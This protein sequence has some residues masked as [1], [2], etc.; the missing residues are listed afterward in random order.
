MNK[1][2]A[3]NWGLNSQD[4]A[5]VAT[6]VQPGEEVV[7]VVKPCITQS[8]PERWLYVGMGLILLVWLLVDWDEIELNWLL[9]LIG[10]LLVLVPRFHR[11]RMERTLYLMTN[12]RVVILEPGL[13]FGT[14]TTAYPL[15][16]GL[17]KSVVPGSGD[18]GD[19]VFAYEPRWKIVE[20][21]LRREISPVGFMAVPQVGR[22]AR[23]IAEQVVAFSSTEAQLPPIPGQVSAPVPQPTIPEPLPMPTDSWGNPRPQEPSRGALIGFGAV[24]ALFSLVFAI[25]GGYR[26][27]ADAR[28]DAEGVRAVATVVKVNAKRTTSKRPAS[29]HGSGISIRIGDSRKD[30]SSYS[31]FPVFQ[32]TDEQGTVHEY[33]SAIGSSEYNYPKGYE[34]P[35]VYERS[36]PSTV[37]P[38]DAGVTTG[39]VF[40]LA[41]GLLFVVGCGIFIAG[42]KMKMKNR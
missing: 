16:A 37:R 2:I 13:L 30:R 36:N 12:R 32:F 1:N 23:L 34:I 31:Y 15:H 41:G 42:L 8:F 38:A 29:H 40:V 35:V 6:A 11:Y 28:L 22:V 10:V 4:S 18:S 27:Y 33:E 26:M 20:Q 25:F 9:L 39:L 7:L 21:K 3:D 14:R 24:F 17:V 5:R 19:I